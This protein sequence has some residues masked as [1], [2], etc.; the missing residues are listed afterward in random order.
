MAAKTK[1]QIAINNKR[2]GKKLEADVVKQ[3]ILYGLT[4]MRAWGSDG[5]ALGMEEDVDVAI[6]GVKIQCKRSKKIPKNII[7]RKGLIQVIR[8]DDGIAHAVVPLWIVLDWI[9]LKKSGGK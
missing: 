5:R 7:P 2:R 1:R 3:A 8:E 6:E 4:A 9:A